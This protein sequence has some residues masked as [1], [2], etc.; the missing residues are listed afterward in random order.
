[1]KQ[2]AIV[3]A[4]N[5]EASIGAVIA[6]LREHAPSFDVVVVDDG[7]TDCT[8][9][10]ASA[11]GAAVIRLPF[12]LGIGGAVQAGYQWA[13]EHGYD[14][15]VQVDGDGQHEA[16]EIRRLLDYL[17]SHPDIH[18]VTGSRFLVVDENNHRSTLARR[19]GIRI[20]AR[21]LSIITGQTVT[22]PTSGF[23]MVSR[24]GIELFA[25]DYPHDYPEVEAVLMI[26]A[27]AL[28][29]AEVPVKMRERTGGISSINAS[30]SLYYMVKVLLAIFVGLFRASPTVRRGDDAPVTA[31]HSI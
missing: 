12:N 21:V 8:S 25:R 30:R 6:D 11:G 19:L 29:S 27:H 26:H 10:R 13:L 18:M 3:P 17:R 24:R 5:E 20:F 31:E 15:A 16:Q 9:A 2:L 1:M 22:D 28:N 23:R 14:Y 7:S 4:Y